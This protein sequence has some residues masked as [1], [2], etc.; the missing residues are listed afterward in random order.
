ML[1]HFG[2]LELGGKD[3]DGQQPAWGEPYTTKMGMKMRMIMTKT[4]LYSTTRSTVNHISKPTI[5]LAHRM[6]RMRI[7]SSQTFNSIV[8]AFIINT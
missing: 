7:I 2:I 4:L 8:S 5:M 1:D 3:S 6:F